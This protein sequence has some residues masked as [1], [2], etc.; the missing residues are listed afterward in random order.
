MVVDDYGF[1][2]TLAE[3]GRDPQLRGIFGQWKSIDGSY[4]S[5]RVLLSAAVMHRGVPYVMKELRARYVCYLGETIY[6]HTPN[7]ETVLPPQREAS[8]RRAPLTCSP[9][10]WSTQSAVPPG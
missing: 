9:V 5:V 7:G 10:N 1:V 6:T 3:T 8:I 2:N 4:A